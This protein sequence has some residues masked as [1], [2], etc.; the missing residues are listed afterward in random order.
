MKLSLTTLAALAALAT[1]PS[2]AGP[3]EERVEVLTTQVL[4]LKQDI[5]LLK[6]MIA[7]DATGNLAFTV[8]G[9]RTDRTGLS[10][11]TVVN[12]NSSTSVG[13]DL[14]ETVGK[15]STTRIGVN[16]S[17]DV[18]RD[19][20]LKVAGSSNAN[21]AVNSTVIVG[22]SATRKVGGSTSDTVTGNAMQQ[23]GGS[24]GV[25]VAHNLTLEAADQIMLKAGLSSI[26]MKKNGEILITGTNVGI[27]ASGDVVLKG[28]RVLT[29]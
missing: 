20:L 25:A 23:V 3:L 10:A 29:N 7:R 26:V 24:M 13:G 8:T 9:N 1:A 28:T 19:D 11:L 16:R 18:V 12:A 4:A 27:R 5:A 15:S 14:T 21:I 6:S 22:A 17:V 2:Q